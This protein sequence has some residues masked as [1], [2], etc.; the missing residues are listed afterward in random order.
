[1]EIPEVITKINHRHLED[2]LGYRKEGK[3]G[4]KTK[5]EV[6]KEIDLKEIIAIIMKWK[7]LI[8]L[9]TMGAVFI[10]GVLNFYIIMP[11]YEAKAVMM[12]PQSTNE[13]QRTTAKEDESLEELAR[14]L[15]ALP[16]MSLNT[17]L[18]QFKSHKLMGNVI[19][20][21]KLDK[22]VYTVVSL[23][24]RVSASIIEETNLIEIKVTDTNAEVAALI[25]NTLSEEYMKFIS[26][27]NKKRMDQS[28]EIFQEQ[29]TALESDLAVANK[30]LIEYNSQPNIDKIQAE[31]NAKKVEQLERNYNIFADRLTEIQIF[32]AVDIGKSTIQIVTPA[33]A[34][35]SPV[36]PNKMLNVGLSFILSLLIGIFLAFPLESYDNNIKN[37]ED[38]KL[39]LGLNVLGRI[40]N[41]KVSLKKW[42]RVNSAAEKTTDNLLTYNLN[43]KSLFSESYR[44]LRTN[45]YFC[46][47]DSSLKKIMITSSGANEGKSTVLA[48]LAATV[49]KTGRKVLVIDAD[50]RR[51]MLHEI[52]QVSNLVGLTDLLIEDRV[53]SEVVQQTKVENLDIMT[54]GPIPPN[55]SELLGSIMMD[56]IL[57][58]I[59]YDMVFIDTPP[60][61][62]VTDSA[63]L[64]D[65]VDGLLLVI[66]SNKVKIDIAKHAMDQ[67][68]K[69]KAKILGV[70]LNNVE[71]KGEEYRNDYYGKEN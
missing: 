30:R 2:H 22:E 34:P 60:T 70:I 4:S 13:Q 61:V 42:N 63:I 47:F 71:L 69:A 44:T 31:L 56:Q 10:S 19:T 55:P 15:S 17:Y 26:D 49:A 58:S 9:L 11:S 25:A 5:P 48:N 53:Q 38:V 27:M 39:H 32:G 14:N 3:M 21:L 18:E 16:K 40:P 46:N 66:N 57:S 50:L 67:L 45:L 23:S 24:E 68:E 6:F 59:N 37:V 65:K 29:I 64:A 43:S 52:F 7:C 28:V 1:M 36:K 51:P 41:A 35:T 8:V 12:V 54:S 20:N 62:T 33:I